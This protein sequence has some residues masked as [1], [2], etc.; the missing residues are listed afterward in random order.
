M[1]IYKKYTYRVTCSDEDQE[2]VALCA[3]F[4]SLS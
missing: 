1:D 3:E 2:H 4:S